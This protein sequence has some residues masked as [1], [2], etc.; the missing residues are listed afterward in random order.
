MIYL[1]QSFPAL[2]E[3]VT[4]FITCM[5]LMCIL[6]VWVNVLYIYKTSHIK[7]SGKKQSA[8]AITLMGSSTRAAS[9]LISLV[10]LENSSNEQ[11]EHSW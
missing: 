8:A 10:F 9:S 2:P 3:M 4:C 5:T 6:Y 7:P 11:I 1:F